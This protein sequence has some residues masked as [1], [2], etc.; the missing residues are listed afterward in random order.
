MD[1]ANKAEKEEAIK[2]R[3]ENTTE[4]KRQAEEEVR[5]AVDTLICAEWN[6]YHPLWGGSEVLQQ[7]GRVKGGEL[8]VSF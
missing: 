3:M 5:G 1:G 4:V 8:I 2:A 7:K 6:R